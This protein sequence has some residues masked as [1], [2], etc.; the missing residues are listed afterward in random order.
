MSFIYNRKSRGPKTV[1][2]GTPETT[3]CQEDCE[4]F[5]TTRCFRQVR[6]A[7]NHLRVLPCRYAILFELSQESLMWNRI[8][9][10]TEIKDCHVSLCSIYITIAMSDHRQS[11]SSC[12]RLFT[13]TCGALLPSS[14]IM[15]LVL[16]V[17]QF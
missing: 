7:F 15:T 10:F 2:C 1:P 16:N 4:L 6:N 14:S 11:C 9:C 12:G 8:E 3:G 5:S 13:G 17:Y